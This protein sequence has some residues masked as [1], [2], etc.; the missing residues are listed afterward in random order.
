MASFVTICS[1]NG[2]KRLLS[3]SKARPSA[4]MFRRSSDTTL[5]LSTLYLLVKSS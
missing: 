2:R 5:S 4:L 1:T 3:F